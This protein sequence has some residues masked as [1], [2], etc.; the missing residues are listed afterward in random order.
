M[1]AVQHGAKIRAAWRILVQRMSFRCSSEDEVIVVAGTETTLPAIEIF[2]FFGL[3]RRLYAS[4]ASGLV[5]KQGSKATI[6][7][8]IV[9]KKNSKYY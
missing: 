3:N 1:L 4:G 7:N 6:S 8:I 2:N 9:Y 5:Y